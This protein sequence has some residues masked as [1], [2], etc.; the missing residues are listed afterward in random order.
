MEGCE[1]SCNLGGALQFQLSSSISTFV[2]FDFFISQHL[3]SFNN[4][5]FTVGKNKMA[6]STTPEKA[7]QHTEKYEQEVKDRYSSE[8]KSY[9]QITGQPELF[10]RSHPWSRL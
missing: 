9:P 5:H 7:A 1:L 4:I 6:D 2:I 3:D 10:D 8:D